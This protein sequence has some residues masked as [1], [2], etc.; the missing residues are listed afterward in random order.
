MLASA[1]EDLVAFLD[2]LGDPVRLEIVRQLAESGGVVCGDLEVRVTKST[3]SHHLRVLRE[4]RV[5]MVV[6]EGRFHR[7][8]VLLEEAEA[9]FP[10]VLSSV[11][12]AD[13]SG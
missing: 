4:S 13:R 5:V 10:G 11:L 8:Q 1:H 3:L 2:A 7:Y 6:R 9:R 12:R